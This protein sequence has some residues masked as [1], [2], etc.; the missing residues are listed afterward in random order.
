MENNNPKEVLVVDDDP[1]Y[2]NLARMR[3]ESVG[4]S[5]SVVSNGRDVMGLLEKGYRPNLMI[6]DVNM[7]NEN[8]LAVVI[9][10]ESFFKNA[11]EGEHPIPIIV[12]TALRSERIRE[13]F[14]AKKVDDYITKPY[15]A[16]DLLEKVRRLVN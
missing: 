13:M 6:L 4:F 5:V 16:E 12:A 11:G 1:D 8:G 2:C 7:E 3:L 14:L 10:L 15:N 9:N